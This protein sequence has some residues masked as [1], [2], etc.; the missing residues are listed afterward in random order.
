MHLTIQAGL[1]NSSITSCIATDVRDGPSR[2][3]GVDV[4]SLFHYMGPSTSILIEHAFRDTPLSKH[5]RVCIE[6]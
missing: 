4:L 3:I 6:E 2:L 1:P 5:I